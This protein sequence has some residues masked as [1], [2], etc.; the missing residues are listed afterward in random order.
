MIGNFIWRTVCV[1]L[2]VV[3]PSA[4]FV[5]LLLYGIACLYAAWGVPALLWAATLLELLVISA[6]LVSLGDM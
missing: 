1:F 3:L 2:R 4:L 5:A 6:Q